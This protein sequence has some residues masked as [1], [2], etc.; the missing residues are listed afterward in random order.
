MSVSSLI[1]NSKNL[2]KEIKESEFKSLA[3]AEP[4]LMKLAILILDVYDTE[5]E[6]NENYK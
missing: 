6:R 2:A 5:E 3:G 4:E 1:L